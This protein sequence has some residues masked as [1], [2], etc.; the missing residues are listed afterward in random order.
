MADE[1]TD[2]RRHVAAAHALFEQ[3]DGTGA[4]PAGEPSA[5]MGVQINPTTFA[6]LVAFAERLGMAPTL[7]LKLAL[8]ALEVE[9]GK[10]TRRPPGRLVGKQRG[11]L[12]GKR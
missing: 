12:E 5:R 9:L 2:I 4:E 8:R 10:G 1:L 7:V 6:E 3:L 11:L